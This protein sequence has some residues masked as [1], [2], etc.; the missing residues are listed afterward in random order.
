MKKALSVLA[1]IASGFVVVFAIEAV[2]HTIWPPPTGV[3]VTNPEDLAQIMDSIP[4]AAIVAVLIAWILG[5]LVGGFVAKKVDNSEGSLPSIITGL[6]LMCA[7]IG[8]MIMIPHP[9]WMWILGIAAPIPSALFGAKLAGT[10][11]T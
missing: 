6:L 11:R 2:S 8:T 1:G 9:A 10:K 3:D 5:A 4:T 7:G